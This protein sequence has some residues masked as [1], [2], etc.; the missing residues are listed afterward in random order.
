MLHDFGVLDHVEAVTGDKLAFD[1]DCLG[2]QRHQLRVDWLVL[3]D[4]QIRLAIVALN[5]HR[6]A[7]FNARL[8]T[9]RVLRPDSTVVNIADHIDNFSTNRDFFRLLRLPLM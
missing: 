1:G 6:K 8:R 9:F 7:H 2:C 3:A 4:E 5:T